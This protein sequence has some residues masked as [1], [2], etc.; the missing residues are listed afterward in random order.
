MRTYIFTQKE[1]EALHEWL[2]GNLKREESNLLH[3]TL[4]R[5]RR[6]EA[7]LIRDFKLLALTIKKLNLTPKLRRHKELYIT[8]TV[9]PITIKVPE[10]R[11]QEYLQL[12]G[13]FHKAQEIAN[14]EHTPIQT[15][16][17]AIEKAAKIAQTLIKNRNKNP[18]KDTHSPRR[19]LRTTN[20]TLP[21]HKHTK[22]IG[23]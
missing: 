7:N 11:L 5:V 20:S 12:I 13:A 8:L 16:L 4:T 2:K 3:T 6:A 22:I 1:R 9:A 10:A 14:D 21:I 17:K 19:A 15:R 23:K 18:N